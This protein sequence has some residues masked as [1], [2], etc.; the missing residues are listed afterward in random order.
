MH[1][2]VCFVANILSGISKKLAGG[3]QG[4]T[5]AVSDAAFALD[6]DTGYA[7]LEGDTAQGAL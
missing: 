5:E 3:E 7:R 1:M 6:S 2:N 4:S